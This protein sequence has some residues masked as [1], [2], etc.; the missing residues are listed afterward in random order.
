[1]TVRT[2]LTEGRVATPPGWSRASLP[3]SEAPEVRDERDVLAVAVR[4]ATLSS[5]DPEAMWRLVEPSTGVTDSEIVDRLQRALPEHDP[6]RSVI[7]GRC[8][9]S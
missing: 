6:R 7:A 9:P 4:R 8:G 5:G 3:R 1:M 2:A